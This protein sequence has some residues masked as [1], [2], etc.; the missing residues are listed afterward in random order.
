M[1]YCSSFAEAPYF[2][3]ASLKPTELSF[4][5]GSASCRSWTCSNGPTIWMVCPLY[6]TVTTAFLV[7]ET[8]VGWALLPLPNFP[9]EGS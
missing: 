6:S 8:S 1:F 7:S 5:I 9:V 2:L 3:T 4:G